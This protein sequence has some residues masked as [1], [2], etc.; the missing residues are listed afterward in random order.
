MSWIEGGS[1]T[2][3]DAPENSKS[4]KRSE[5]SMGQV[6]P[7]N[8]KITVPSSKRDETSMSVLS[9]KSHETDSI[10]RKT[11]SRTIPG[12]LVK[13]PKL[14]QDEDDTDKDNKVSS[15]VERTRQKS[16]RVSPHPL[17]N[18]PPLFD[19]MG[20][21]KGDTHYRGRGWS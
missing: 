19:N 10:P 9:K 2:E 5:S 1:T 4:K 7:K 12:P 6:D 20:D 18:T 21:Y 15:S 13:A 14:T 8:L 17:L 11:K 16:V 3:S